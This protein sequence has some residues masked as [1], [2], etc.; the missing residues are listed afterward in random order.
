MV[1]NKALGIRKA[2]S[3]GVGSKLRNIPPSGERGENW[4]ELQ[5]RK[6]HQTMQVDDGEGGLGPAM[7][8]GDGMVPREASRGKDGPQ[9]C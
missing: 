7:A 4:E 8:P 3:E 9:G 6:G 1:G 5:T 2:Q